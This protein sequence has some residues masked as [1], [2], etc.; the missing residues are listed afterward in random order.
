MA[1]QKEL[2]AAAKQAKKDIAVRNKK[3]E[4]E[5][6]AKSQR[7]LLAIK[8]Q[9]DPIVEITEEVKKTPIKSKKVTEEEE[10]E[11][12]RHQLEVDRKKEKARKNKDSWDVKI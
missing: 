8:T 10:I 9:K 12:L 6:I 3:E 11:E 2:K 5:K 7:T 1:T 4:E